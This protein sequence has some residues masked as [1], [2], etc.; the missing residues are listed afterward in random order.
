[1]KT[2]HQEGRYLRAKERVQE[3][4]SFYSNLTAYCMVIP[5]L[6]LVNYYTT[7]FYWIVFPALGWGLGLVLHAMKVFG[8]NLF[9]GK[10]WEERKIAEYMKDAI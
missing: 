7:G 3:E 5:M 9:L 6:G 8:F 4:K 2:L 1:M 10:N